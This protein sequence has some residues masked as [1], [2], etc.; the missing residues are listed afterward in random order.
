M[1]RLH[2]HMT[3]KDMD[4]NIQFYSQMFASKPNKL[5]DDYAKWELE[6]PRV[7]FA[8]STHG[9]KS[10]LNHL[11]IQ[12]ESNE[13]LEALVAP[14]KSLNTPMLEEKD[15]D[16]CYAHSDKYWTKDPQGIP[17]E[18]FHTMNEVAYYKSESNKCCSNKL[19]FACC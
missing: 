17:W 8:I 19:K 2:V 7:N 1:K 13:E 5:K 6:D 9:F 4:A 16:C 3:V 15:T 12:V 18:T 10:G 11:G 14:L